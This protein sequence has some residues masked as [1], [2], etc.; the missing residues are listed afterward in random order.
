ML[1]GASGSGVRW[2]AGPAVGRAGRRGFYARGGGGARG[3]KEEEER[4][5]IQFGF[6]C[7]VSDAKVLERSFC[8]S[9]LD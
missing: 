7:R 8:G 2:A 3:T 5:K 9:S 4:A 6:S 1:G